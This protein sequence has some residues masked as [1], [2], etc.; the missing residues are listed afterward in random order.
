V[1]LVVLGDARTR[2]LHLGMCNKWF[3]GSDSSDLPLRKSVV[4]LFSSL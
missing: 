2:F 1:V 3:L 4:F